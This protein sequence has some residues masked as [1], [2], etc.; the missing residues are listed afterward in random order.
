MLFP[1]IYWTNLIN[2]TA[3]NAREAERPAA[4]LL[5]VLV[6][7]SIFASIGLAFILYAE[8]E[9]KSSSNFRESTDF[10]G[11]DLD[12]EMAFALFLQDLIFGNKDDASGVFSALR[13]HDMLRNMYGLNYKFVSGNSGP[14]AFTDTDTVM[15][16]GVPTAITVNTF[17]QP[18]S[19]MG[20]LHY[21]QDPDFAGADEYYL[22][23][24]THF[25]DYNTATVGV[26]LP[27]FAGKKLRD[28]ERLGARAGLNQPRGQYS[29]GFCPPY[30]AADFNCMF[31]AAMKADGTIMVPSFHRD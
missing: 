24:Y 20:R 26:D 18:F 10:R 5:I 30:T 9:A 11:P 17:K 27:I 16:N 14:I 21:Q 15:V 13:G 23:N 25:P 29:G 8:S 19:G 6:I 28:P 31:L 7:L 4:V 1:S 12:P 3:D 22:V 2:G